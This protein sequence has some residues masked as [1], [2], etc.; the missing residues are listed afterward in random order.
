MSLLLACTIRAYYCM[1]H[2]H[3]L[4]ARPAHLRYKVEFPLGHRCP[5]KAINYFKIVL[6]MIHP[7]V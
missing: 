2:S 3:I 1:V 7:E 6:E 4:N 5:I